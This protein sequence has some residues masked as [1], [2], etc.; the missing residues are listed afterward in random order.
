VAVGLALLAW[1]ASAAL[2]AAHAG[3][4]VWSVGVQAPGAVFQVA[5]APPPMVVVRPP[6]YA[7]SSTYVMAPPVVMVDQWGNPVRQGY[8]AQPAPS[9]PWEGGW[10]GGREGERRHHHHHHHH[11]DNGRHNGWDR[12]RW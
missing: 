12:D 9:R 6:M 7:T 10:E 1:A 3:E 8:I 2:H 11:Q 5:N 4:L